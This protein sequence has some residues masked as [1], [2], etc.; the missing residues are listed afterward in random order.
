MESIQNEKPKRKRSVKPKTFFFR[1]WFI[2]QLRGIFRRYPPYYLC[3]N[4]VK[5]EYFI[6]SKKGKPMKRVRFTCAQCKEKH[7]NSN[8][9][10]DH[11]NPVIDPKVGFPLLPD[12]RDDWLT[13]ISRLFCSIENLQILCLPCHNAKSGKETKTRVK[14]RKKRKELV[15]IS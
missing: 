8:T 1:S 7:G 3:R 12:G 5:E 4:A 11:I 9:V 14:F 10:V 13:Y 6:P 2:H 15:D